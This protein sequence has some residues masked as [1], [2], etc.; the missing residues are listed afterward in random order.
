MTRDESE[1]TIG[2]IKKLSFS[3][4]SRPRPT[5][6]INFYVESIRL[7]CA[8]DEKK[9]IPDDKNIMHIIK[10]VIKL[11]PLD[12]AMKHLL[13]H[14]QNILFLPRVKAILNLIESK[15]FHTLDD[16]INKNILFGRKIFLTTQKP[17][18]SELDRYKNSFLIINDTKKN[19]LSIAYINQDGEIITWI[20]IEKTALNGIEID[21]IKPNHP[22]QYQL[23][24]ER[25]EKFRNILHSNLP[26]ELTIAD[27]LPTQEGKHL[28]IISA[29]IIAIVRNETEE[30][31]PYVDEILQDFLKEDK[32]E[33]IIYI[34]QKLRDIEEPPEADLFGIEKYKKGIAFI[35]NDLELE[36]YP[37]TDDETLFL[38]QSILANG[39]WYLLEKLIVQGYRN[40]YSRLP[41]NEQIET[42]FTEVLSANQYGTPV[43]PPQDHAQGHATPMFITCETADR[44][45]YADENTQLL[46]LLSIPNPIIRW[47]FYM[48]FIMH[49]ILGKHVPDVPMRCWPNIIRVNLSLKNTEILSD[50][51]ILVDILLNSRKS[52]WFEDEKKLSTI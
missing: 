32:W 13:V 40:T 51:R 46:M 34:L 39:K 9:R 44:Y 15:D 6:L 1:L 43:I 47:S 22:L 38:S 49:P 11:S 21:D 35:N 2:E 23:P 48:N 31:I 30:I 18:Q 52:Y 3:L 50:P 7:S 26:S 14:K 24:E 17:G 12:K 42:M 45:Q 16:W 5:E 36:N 20:N 41:K 29:A 27:Q 25:L 33:E 37:Y 10:I 4:N 19:L 8:T 28:C